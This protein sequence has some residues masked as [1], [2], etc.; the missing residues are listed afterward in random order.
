MKALVLLV[1]AVVLLLAHPLSA[2]VKI[3]DLQFTSSF[4]SL[5]AA[6]QQSQKYV[7]IDWFTD[8]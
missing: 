2:E 1:S 7:V 4:D 5:M 3:G 8:W 6:A